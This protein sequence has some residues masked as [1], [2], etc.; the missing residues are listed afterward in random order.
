MNDILHITMLGLLAGILGTGSGGLVALFLKRPGPGLL[1]FFLGFS[2]GIMLAIVLMDLVPEAVEAGNIYLA[3]LGL[4]L[5][6]VLILLLDLYLPHFH[7]F[8]ASEENNSYIRTGILLG[9]GI[10][11]HNLPEGIAIGSGF[12]AA[13]TLGMTLAVTIALHNIPEGIAMAAPLSA[14]GLGIIRIVFFTILAGL[15][16]GAG[17]FIGASIG[18]ISPAVLSLALSFAGGAMLYIIFSELIP[19]SQEL[20]KGHSGTFGAVFGTIVGIIV[21]ALL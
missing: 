21:L 15:P 4:L 16:M 12:I 10:A 11:L 14:G 6:A 2:G 19:G 9:L 1:S 13:P 7:L 18:S 8:E 17:A 5:G 3:I 20:A